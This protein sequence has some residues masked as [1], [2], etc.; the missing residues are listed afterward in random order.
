MTLLVYLQKVLDKKKINKD[1][2]FNNLKEINEAQNR[3]DQYIKNVI[4]IQKIIRGHLSRIKYHLSLEEINTKTII[5][6]L[7]EKKKMRIHQHSIEIISFFITKYINKQRKNKTKNI[8]YEQYKIHCSDLI[9]A[10]LRGV[11]IRKHV[12]ERLYLEKMAKNKIFQHILRYRTILILKSNTIQNLL[13]DIANIK[14]QLKNLDKDKD[15]LKIKELKNKLS[16]NFNLFYDTYYYNKE[17]CNWAMGK[18]TYERWDKKYFDILNKKPEKKT[19]NKNKNKINI[20]SDYNGYS[21]YLLDF[22]NDSDDNNDSGINQNCLTSTNRNNHYN[23]TMNSTKNNSKKFNEFYSNKKYETSKN[24]SEFKIEELKKDKNY[25]Y[26]KDKINNSIKNEDKSKTDKYNNNEINNV[27]YISDKNLRINYI[28]EE[29]KKFKKEINNIDLNN[30]NNQLIYGN[31]ENNKYSK[32]DENFKKSSTN[33]YQQREE[34][35]I[36]PLKNNNILNCENPFGLRDNNFQKN[37]T[38][39]QPNNFRNSLQF[40]NRLNNNQYNQYEKRYETGGSI[41]NRYI[42][43]KKPHI[44]DDS[45]EYGYNR[46]KSQ[47]IKNNILNRDEKPI[48][49][50]IDYDAMFGEEGEINFEGDPFGGVKQ[51]ETNKN[52]KFNKSNSTAGRKKPVYD[53]RKAIEEAK[54]KE[55]KEA[56]E[57]KK[58]K[59]SEFREFLKEMKKIS[60]EEKLKNKKCDNINKDDKKVKNGITN[61]NNDSFDYRKCVSESMNK[62]DKEISNGNN[63]YKNNYDEDESKNLEYEIKQ[64][65]NKN[66]KREKSLNKSSNQV[67]RKKLHDLEKAAA[68]ILNIKSAKSKIECWF[69]NNNNNNGNKYLEYSLKNTSNNRPNGQNKIRKVL[70]CDYDQSIILNK[71]MEN[72]IINYVDKKLSQLN[73]KIDEINDVFSIESYFEQKK[74]KMKNYI[75]I[76]YIN[77]NTYYVSNY[78]DEIYDSLIADINKEY[79]NLK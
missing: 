1:E 7:H 22:Y 15:M 16:K 50:G 46:I 54:L 39:K 61:K 27:K 49:R 47:Q 31:K 21:N 25:C 65:E 24:V 78:S 36:K 6:Y 40:Y 3:K 58:E 77:E 5:E 38:Y 67:R 41:D 59:H 35:P 4:K 37:K 74:L 30:I 79:K 32:K 10:R 69:D 48:G 73:L 44:D 26:G 45:N 53:A 66:V 71:K 64:K 76:P 52:K 62:Y 14:Y 63:I 12:K 43:E 72:K 51:F 60:K 75:N 23:S 9:K 68:P 11:L 56:K 19:I 17:N 34:R 42:E 33:I 13:I 8:L 29:N 55:A 2:L 57:G 20:K 28:K 70:S 18:K